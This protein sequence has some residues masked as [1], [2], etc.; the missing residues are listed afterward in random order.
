M[1]LR[2]AYCR[3]PELCADDTPVKLM[4]VIQNFKIYFE[5]EIT[6]AVRIQTVVFKIMTL[7]SG[8]QCFGGIFYLHLRD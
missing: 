8:Y 3:K 2:T 7:I 6:T 5:T 1:L 4:R